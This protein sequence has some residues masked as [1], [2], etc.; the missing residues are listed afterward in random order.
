MTAPTASP[1][2]G[3]IRRNDPAGIRATPE[4][5]ATVPALRPRLYSGQGK[6]LRDVEAEVRV[7]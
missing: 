2:P 6:G 4:R 3:P 7:R 5:R 1:P